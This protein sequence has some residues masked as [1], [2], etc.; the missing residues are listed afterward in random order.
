MIQSAQGIKTAL[1]HWISL[2]CGWYN[3]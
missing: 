2:T 1:F 3:W